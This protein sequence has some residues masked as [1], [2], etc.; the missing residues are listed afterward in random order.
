MSYQVLARKW[1]PNRFEEVVGQQHILTALSNAL[2]QGR[3]HHAYLFSGTRGVG[4]TTIAR[5]FAKGLN[6]EKGI[7]S[8]PC[9]VCSNCKAIEEGR[10]IDLL[11]IDAAS[12]T[13]VE[14]TREL[15]DNVQYK[16]VEGRYKVYLI[17]EVHMLSRHS[18]NALLKTLEEPPEYVKFL[19]ATTD[20]QKLPV[21]ILSRCLQFHLKALD[22]SQITHHLE[23]I[24]TKEA[25][26]F[27]ERAIIQ[28]AKAAQGSIRDALSLT[29]QAIAMSAG[30]I[31]SDIVH[32]MLGILDSNQAIDII[33]ALQQGNGESLMSFVQLAADKGIEW[34]QLLRQIAEQLH[35]IAMAQL[36][37]HDFDEDNRIGFLAKMMA[38]QDVQFYYQVILVGLKELEFS[39]EPRSGVEMTL[40]RALAF[41]PKKVVIEDTSENFIQKSGMSVTSAST[42]SVG[43]DNFA[44]NHLSTAMETQQNHLQYGDL[45]VEAPQSETMQ[46]EPMQKQNAQHTSNEQR[47]PI[48]PSSNLVDFEQLPQTTEQTG[49]SDEVLNNPYLTQV[50]RSSSYLKG[51][52]KKD[53]VS[54]SH[55]S[56]THNENDSFQPIAPLKSEKQNTLRSLSDNTMTEA[57]SSEDSTG[58]QIQRTSFTHL[59]ETTLV[60]QPNDNGVSNSEDIPD[61]E[62]GDEILTEDYH[63]QWSDPKLLEQDEQR[64]RPSDIR[65]AILGGTAQ[66]LKDK[67]KQMAIERDEWCAVAE[68]L[69]L[70]QGVLRQIVIHS[71]RE[72]EGDNHL[73]LTID[74]NIG[75]AFE[76]DGFTVELERLLSDYYQKPM[77]LTL[78]HSDKISPNTP[79]GICRQIYEELKEES[80]N[81]LLEDEKV[82]L[83]R[84]IFD[85]QI[86]KDSVRPVA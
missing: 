34:Q 18:F 20:P 70:Q 61:A 51:Q 73:T 58:E 83:L 65:Q 79:S 30:N 16:P 45:Q 63:W 22:K 38:P 7:T 28:L 74:P 4:K 3:L 43:V 67:I 39:P 31:S 80:Y 72:E 71:C 9:G 54:K 69:P 6:C 17:D 13:K 75:N 59:V 53:K 36:L 81:H 24:L 56:V 77:K 10:F 76:A 82:S 78:T 35:E 85:A 37:N 64:V 46:Y 84:S 25:I 12:R 49:E 40:L 44:D 1:R 47:L 23:N 26:P 15:L 66:E 60:K 62:I 2:E 55:P 33:Q 48:A 14:D 32:D 8:E 19:L 52:K 50:L 11:E 86:D 27:E 57:Q 5:L 42:E 41:H 29:D 21:T 68:K